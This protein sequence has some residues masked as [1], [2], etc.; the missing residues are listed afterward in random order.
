MKLFDLNRDGK[1]V[2]KNEDTTP[3]VGFYFKSIWRKLSKLISINLLMIVQFLPLLAAFFTRIWADTTPSVSDISFPFWQ[4]VSKINASP[5]EAFMAAVSGIQT[6]V[7]LLSAWTLIQMGLWILL[8]VGLFGICNVGFTY[9]LRE[10]LRG[11]PVF[12]FSDLKYAIKKNGKQ[13]FLV[14]LAD[15]AILFL[16]GFD[17]FVMNSTSGALNNIIFFVILAIAFLYL[18]MRFYIYLMLI[19]FDMKF[20]KILKNALIFVVLGIKRNLLAV[21]WIVI[22]L[23]FNY[24]LLILY[25]PLGIALPAIYFLGVST[26]TTAYAA[27][28]VIEKYMIT[29]YE[30]DTEEE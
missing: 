2:E 11:N 5:F 27:W 20:T 6:K 13:G 16:L 30:N 14:G 23:C 15:A 17:I 19:T 7:P 29:P 10:M 21:L 1:G 8:F 25:L 18:I 3:G 28:P 12:I 24:V 4:G 9:L 26:F 22:L